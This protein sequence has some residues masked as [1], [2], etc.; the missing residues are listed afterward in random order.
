MVGGPLTGAQRKRERGSDSPHSNWTSASQTGPYRGGVAC[1]DQFCNLQVLLPY[2]P[3]YN[4][5]DKH[6]SGNPNLPLQRD[7]VERKT[8]SSCLSQTQGHSELY[9]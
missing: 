7:I 4:L 9:G 8:I 1:D 3:D 6:P 5:S 2:S